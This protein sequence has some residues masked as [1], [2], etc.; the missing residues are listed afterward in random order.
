MITPEKIKKKAEKIYR[1]DYLPCLATGGNIF[2]IEIWNSTLK[3]SSRSELDKVV[4]TLRE[5]SKES[6]EYGYEIFYKEQYKQKLG[7]RLLPYRIAFITESDF[8]KFLN[9]DKEVDKFRKNTKLIQE[10]I[11]CLM[12]WVSKNTK[13]V[14]KYHGRWNEI[15]TICEYFINNPQPNLFA[16]ELPIYVDTKFIENHISI[17]D[18]L[19]QNLLPEM[20]YYADAETFYQR[21]GL[22]TKKNFVRFRF[23]TS[24]AQKHCSFLY[25][26]VVVSISEFALNPLPIKRAIIVENEMVYL[27]LPKIFDSIGIFGKGKAAATLSKVKWLGG[28]ELIYWGDIDANG[29]QILSNFRNSFPKTKSIMMDLETLQEFD[30]FV[31]AGSSNT[32]S[33]LPN[34][35]SLED[36]AF[37]I[38]Y[39]KKMRLEQEKINQIWINKYF[40]LH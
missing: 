40:N 1:E 18:K 9:K 28:I 14:I 3:I 34:L 15:L 27:T 5:G 7:N 36:E 25:S 24:S 4:T 29:Y 19:L 11:P 31:N 23:L 30:K 32:D 13:E 35:T 8:L 16:R 39:S 12:R 6:T 38:V 17:L 20:A 2:P 22:K 26:D 10:R 21:V 33:F 37:E